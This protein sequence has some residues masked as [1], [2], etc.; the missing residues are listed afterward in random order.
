[1]LDVIGALVI[2]LPFLVGLHALWAR[3]RT[4]ADASFP[5]EL[6]LISCYCLVGSFPA[7]AILSP[8]NWDNL[9]ITLL[10]WAAFVVPLGWLG[11]CK[12]WSE[13]LLRM[14]ILLSILMCS[15]VFSGTLMTMRTFRDDLVRS[16]GTFSQDQIENLAAACNQRVLGYFSPPYDHDRHWWVPMESGWAVLA[17]CG[18]IRLNHR[19]ADDSGLIGE[20]WQVGAPMDYVRKRGIHWQNSPDVI[21]GFANANNVE[22][23]VESARTPIP[24][25]MRAFLEPVGEAGPYFLWRIA[26]V[27]R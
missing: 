25:E 14:R 16:P 2:G 22:I 19:T 27:P 8:D 21:L 11:L 23:I 9:H 13:S 6:V 12:L 4:K 5:R 1:L 18:L 10:M 15:V 20:F 24:D 17:K 3:G 7:Y 26:K